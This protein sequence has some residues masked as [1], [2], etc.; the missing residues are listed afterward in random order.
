MKNRIIEEDIKTIVED[1]RNYSH[2]LNDKTLLITGSNGF[3]G[4]YL[5]LTIDFLNKNILEKPCKVISVDNFITGSKNF[6]SDSTNISVI[7]HDVKVPLKIEEPIDFIIH[8]AGIASPFYYTKFPLETIDVGTVGTKNMLELAKEKNVESFMFLSS[9][10]VYGDPDPRF[11]PTP[12][13]YFGNVNCIGPR[14][15]Y[16]E[17]KR[18]GETLCMAYFKLFNLP[19]K[20]VRPFNVYGPGIKPDDFRVLPNFIYNAL[21]GNSLP[22]YGGG[23]HTR[24]FCYITDAI[25]GFYKVLLSD[26]S[27]EVF[28]VG[29]QNEEISII[30]LAKLV[31]GIFGKKIAI[32]MIPN[33]NEVYASADPKRRC[34]DLTKIKKLIGY[35]S[36]V[37]LEAGLKRTAQ[38]FQEEFK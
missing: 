25:M 18:L 13:T 24:A 30:D 36:K 37:N 12:E 5:V 26:S 23:N 1:L 4:R 3:I 14:S 31:V 9:S 28:N 33:T 19:I 17:S 22:V 6:I 29:N 38:W 2:K 11:V 16:D 10:E 7:N 32:Q 15:C 34:P 21:K 8:A 35:N 27:G 20:I